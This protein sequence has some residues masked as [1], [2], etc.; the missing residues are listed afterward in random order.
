MWSTLLSSSGYNNKPATHTQYNYPPII[1]Q[2]SETVTVDSVEYITGLYIVAITIAYRLLYRII[3]IPH[4][5]ITVDQLRSLN[6]CLCLVSSQCTCKLDGVVPLIPDPPP[7]NSTTMHS[8]LVWQDQ[9]LC[10]CGTANFP[11]KSL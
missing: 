4:L 10:L 2:L 1:P 8:R 3:I 6:I 5:S 7:A 9:N 11:A